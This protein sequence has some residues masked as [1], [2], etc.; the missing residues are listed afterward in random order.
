MAT[1]NYCKSEGQHTGK[2]KCCGKVIAEYNGS[3]VY[4]PTESDMR[5]VEFTLTD[6]YILIRKISSVEG[7][8]DKRKIYA[9]Y[10]LCEIDRVVYPYY[11]QRFGKTPV[12]RVVNIDGTDFVLSFGYKEKVLLKIAQAF[13]SVVL[14]V[15]EGNGVAITCCENPFVDFESCVNRVSV[16]A[17]QFALLSFEQFVAPKIMAIKRPQIPAEPET[18]SLV[19][20]ESEWEKTV[21][22]IPAP[23]VE[24]SVEETAEEETPSLVDWESEWEKT[25]TDIPAPIVET[26]AEEI[27]E[28]ETPS[29]VDWESEWEKTVSDIAESPLPIDIK[30]PEPMPLSEWIALWETE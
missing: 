10:D 15:V 14:N 29:L 28:I 11:T 16:S 23:A 30:K 21:T 7:D 12:F 8:K 5:P 26:P 20:W 25:V 1:C 3:F 4:G 2:C 6:K 9:F 17:A 18:P 19:D 13:K 22:D 24:T 27:A